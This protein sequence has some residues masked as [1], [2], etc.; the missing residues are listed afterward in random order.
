VGTSVT[1]YGMAALA[2]ASAAGFTAYLVGRATRDYL[3]H[4]D[5]WDD[6]S[7][8]QML[9]SVLADLTPQSALY[10]LKQ[11]IDINS[12]AIEGD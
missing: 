12:P 11:D 10:P 3:Q 1:A 6:E 9:R 7:P 2:Q 4:G 5:R 8:A